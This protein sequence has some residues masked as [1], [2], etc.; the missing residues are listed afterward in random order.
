[1]VRAPSR[2]V[3]AEQGLEDTVGQRERGTLG[4]E[5][6]TWSEAWSYLSCLGCLESLQC[7][8]CWGVHWVGR[9][10][11]GVP[12]VRIQVRERKRT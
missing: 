7:R 8:L 2:R 10:S 1:M 3:I 12:I 4:R 9:L 6:V 11:M 5:R